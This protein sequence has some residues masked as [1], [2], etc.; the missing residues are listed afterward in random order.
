MKRM[1]HRWVDGVYICGLPYMA[2]MWGYSIGVLVERIRVGFVF[3]LA[4]AYTVGWEVEGGGDS[5]PCR[6]EYE[7]GNKHLDMWLKNR[8][9]WEYTR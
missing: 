4:L 8:N 2:N 1:Q 7:Q 9:S 5:R 6:E 3:Y